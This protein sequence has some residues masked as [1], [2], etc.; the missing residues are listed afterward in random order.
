MPEKNHLTFNLKALNISAK[1]FTNLK[2]NQF[3]SRHLK[4]GFGSSVAGGHKKQL[5]IQ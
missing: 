2:I 4:A 1:Y 3:I 5:F